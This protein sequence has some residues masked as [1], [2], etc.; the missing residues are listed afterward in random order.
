MPLPDTVI[1]QSHLRAPKGIIYSA[2]GAG[3][4]TF[5]ASADRPL[6]VDCE[7]GAAHVHCHR[8]RY[9]CAWT[10][11]QPW[12]DCLAAG[13]HDYQDGCDRFGG[14]GLA[15]RLRHTKHWPAICPIPHDFL[16]IFPPKIFRNLYV[17]TLP[18][19]LVHFSD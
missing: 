7:N 3:K 6:I 10:E 13:D 5:G 1:S 9:L 2:P 14:L 15:L 17:G 19:P 16:L 11:I 4:T 8:T 18:C 12:L